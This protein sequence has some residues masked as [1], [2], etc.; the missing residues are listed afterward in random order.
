M[1]KRNLALLFFILFLLSAPTLNGCASIVQL[2]EVRSLTEESLTKA[3]TAESKSDAAMQR[4]A[5]AESEARSAMQAA[6][7]AKRMAKESTQVDAKIPEDF[8]I[9]LKEA[10]EAI[11]RAEAITAVEMPSRK[12]FEKKA[13]YFNFDSS[14]LSHKSIRVLDEKA[15]W[16]KANP[17][18]SVVIEASADESGPPDYNEWLAGRRGN[19]VKDYLIEAGIDPSRMAVEAIGEITDGL[20]AE[21]RRVRF[22]IQ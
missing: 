13:V 17:D 19:R 1:I 15:E 22:H 16:M 8:E 20:P 18:A 4:A 21:N 3:E 2:R 6:E 9:L 11:A 5:A 12:H 10:R 7:E 14:Y